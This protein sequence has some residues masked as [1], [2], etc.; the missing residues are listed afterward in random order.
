MLESLNNGESRFAC[1]EATI[2]VNRLQVKPI[3]FET[4]CQKYGTKEEAIEA[5]NEAMEN[6]FVEITGPC[7]GPYKSPRIYPPL[8]S[9]PH[10]VHYA[11]PNPP[12][13]PKPQ[14]PPA[15]ALAPSVSSPP[16]PNT[17]FPSTNPSRSFN[18]PFDDTNVTMRSPKRE[19]RAVSISGGQSSRT[20]NVAQSSPT[21]G[22]CSDI[23][24]CNCNCH[25]KTPSH[26]LESPVRQRKDSYIVV[27]SPQRRVKKEPRP[28]SSASLRSQAASP[29]IRWVTSPTPCPKNSPTLQPTP[30]VSPSGS[31]LRTQS[32]SAVQFS[33]PLA[34]TSRF[35]RDPSPSRLG[36]NIIHVI[37]SDSEDDSYPAASESESESSGPELVTPPQS[38]HLLSPLTSPKL[39]DTG[40]MTASLF[41]AGVSGSHSPRKKD[42]TCGPIPKSRSEVS[43]RT[44]NQESKGLSY[45][46]G[47]E[48]EDPRSP[49]QR[50]RIHIT[51]EPMLVA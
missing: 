39:K 24:T 34:S 23:S 48:L 28:L 14:A 5:F 45:V 21:K 11:G 13:P 3:V 44:P 16:L 7:D 18:S 25:I 38:S 37:S 1:M 26:C 46:V 31:I 36:P 20:R 35:P 12:N 19:K 10:P 2:D 27:T 32:A 6:G 17:P 41:V 8:T 40:I 49:I 30:R 4:N 47:N 22:E 33:S 43:R 42:A 50:N 29:P 9:P 51:G 15:S